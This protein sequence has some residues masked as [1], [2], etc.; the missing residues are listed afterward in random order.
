MRHGTKVTSS[1]GLNA[2]ETVTVPDTSILLSEQDED[3]LFDLNFPSVHSVFDILIAGHTA[4]TDDVAV[5]IATATAAATVSQFFLL[6][7]MLNNIGIRS[8]CAY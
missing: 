7:I 8:C 6:L 2:D 4:S 5:V 1:S 3:K